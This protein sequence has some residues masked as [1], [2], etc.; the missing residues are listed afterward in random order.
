MTNLAAEAL[1]TISRIA[2][3]TDAW[4]PQIN[5]VVRVLD[6]LQKRLAARGYRVNIIGPGQFRTVPCP[7]YPEIPLA[8]RPGPKMAN[9][10]AAFGPHAIHV[11][12]EGPLGL[13]ARVWCRRH[14][15]P[16]TSAYHTKFPEYVHARLHLPLPWLYGAMRRFHA[17]SASVLAPSP[18]VYREL[19]AH[20]FHNVRPWSHGVDASV[21]RPQGKD[22]L[23]LP[24]P[25][26][27]FVGRVA[28]EKNLTAFLDTPMAGT[29]VVVGGGPQ[30][31]ALIRKYPDVHFR[32]A[33][34]DA[35]LSRY[36][37][38]ADV[39]VFPSLTDTFGLTML[40]ALASGVPVAAYP[41]TGPL[42]VLE[43]TSAGETEFGCLDNDLAYAAARAL[44]KDPAAC[45]AHALK[46]SW[47]RVADEFLHNLAPVPPL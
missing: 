39:F 10:L 20:G 32:I 25:V 2:I 21:F 8:L 18:S 9:L 44:T 42:D 6:T 40:E 5:G 27:M 28:I 1:P 34:G 47:D 35:E 12:T 31:D 19:T 3:V 7:T 13:A 36:F 46:F 43:I 37:S 22:F 4:Y 30:R 23:D 11:A 26:H 45:R 14:N 17:P 24:R 15:V 38:A 33:K 41:V 29:K 16:F